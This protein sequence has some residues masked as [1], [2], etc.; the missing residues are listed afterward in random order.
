MR[1]RRYVSPLRYPG[2]KAR[3]APYLEQMFA[4]QVSDMEVEVWLEPFAGGA[5]AGLSMLN[6]DA[7]GEIWLTEKN[8]AL[9]ALWRTML[10]APEV[11]SERV[12]Q[13]TPDLGLWAWAR[14][15]VTRAGCPGTSDADTAFAALV[16]NRCSRS[17]MVNPRVGPIG[18][19]SQDGPWT[20]AS[21]WNAPALAE[22][23]R[24]VGYLSSRIRFAQGDAVIAIAD[25]A[26]SGIEDEVLVFVDPPY[27]REGNR[28]YANGM[29][30]DDHQRLAD[31]LNASPTRWM[32]TYDDEPTVAADLYPRRRV[33]AYRIA[34]TANRARIATEHAVVSDN[35]VLP[36]P[37]ELVAGAEATWV[38]AQPA[39]AA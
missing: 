11:L 10:T 34:N 26:G 16:L 24:H 36:E 30:A 18:G 33:L 25:L 19:K 39:A 9:A 23:I 22:R 35:L 13:T 27:L 1:S 4:Q 2:G 15:Q 14:E 12:E 29:D 20:L 28:L 7:V 6:D 31:A 8:P 3:M 37:Y 17:G 38:R 21:R 5:G 32:L